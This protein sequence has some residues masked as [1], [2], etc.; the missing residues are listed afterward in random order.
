MY[1]PAGYS[2]KNGPISTALV[3]KGIKGRLRE[4]S[5]FPTKNA[6]PDPVFPE[7]KG[8]VRSFSSR[9]ADIGQD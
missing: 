9:P 7:G 8:F 1:G 2:N 3:S 5:S 6:F 4:K